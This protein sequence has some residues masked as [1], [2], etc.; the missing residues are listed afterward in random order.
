MVFEV[1]LEL[2]LI[3]SIDLGLRD[4]FFGNVGEEF[5]VLVILFVLFPET[6]FLGATRDLDVN[7]VEVDISANQVV[8]ALPQDLLLLE[9]HLHVR[10][11][12]A[13]HVLDEKILPLLDVAVYDPSEL[14]W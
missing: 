12:D 14:Y 8:L 5:F 10:P 2:S 6:V 7:D 3:N 13:P 1:P 9:A 11:M 4:V